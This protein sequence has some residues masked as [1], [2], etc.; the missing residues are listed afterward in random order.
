MNRTQLSMC[1]LFSFVYSVGGFSLHALTGAKKN[2]AF[3]GG[4]VLVAAT[5]VRKAYVYREDLKK[6]L[7]EEKSW[8]KRQ[9][10][11][12]KL[13]NAHRYIFWG[14]VALVAIGGYGVHSLVRG[15]G[16]P[17]PDPSS[18]GNGEIVHHPHGGVVRDPAVVPHPAGDPRAVPGAAL[19]PSGATTPGAGVVDG[20][21]PRRRA[22]GCEHAAGQPLMRD[23]VSEMQTWWNR[24]TKL[25]PYENAAAPLGPEFSHIG[26]SSCRGVG[27]ATNQDA[28]FVEQIGEYTVLG[29]YDG[30]G[31]YD[32][33]RDAGFNVAAYAALRMPEILK[34]SLDPSDLFSTHGC[35]MKAHE[36]IDAEVL[37]YS[38]I[39]GDVA[40]STAVTALIDKNNNLTIGHAGDSRAVLCDKDGN[41]LQA[42]V[43]HKPDSP[44][45]QTRIERAGGTVTRIAG[46]RTPRI[47][48]Y[49][50]VARS[51][52]DYYLRGNAGEKLVSSTPN[53]FVR[54]NVPS[55]SFLIVAC[56]GLWDL[57]HNQEECEKYCRGV[58]TEL[59]NGKSPQEVADDS[60]A[61]GNFT[62]DNVTAIVYRFT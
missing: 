37:G 47:N 8:L 43:D 22:A 30:H 11:N 2:A 44:K 41:I 38:F 60:R 29:V 27:R 5:L 42:T 13:K 61:F 40:G 35:L 17:D 46:G 16:L 20:E 34:E 24:L 57:F 18:A 55:G 62:R 48:G 3:A 39:G 12:K 10:L 45:E 4:G 56:D 59:K 54:P 58:A 31:R 36:M 6:K 25:G 49:L 50:A 51:F 26:V 52:G 19:V 33:K 1:L 15:G 9:E 28:E 14:Y 7:Q 21:A 23:I 32:S 53:V